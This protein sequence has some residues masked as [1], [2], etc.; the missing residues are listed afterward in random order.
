MCFVWVSVTK[1][2]SNWLVWSVMC[3]CVLLCFWKQGLIFMN[4]TW[5]SSQSSLTLF[6]LTAGHLAV[7]Q[8]HTVWFSV[9]HLWLCS[10]PPCLNDVLETFFSHSQMHVASTNTL[11]I[12]RQSFISVYTDTFF[13]HSQMHVASTNTLFIA[14]QSFISVYTDTFYI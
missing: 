10:Y 14:H 6:C 2:W 3:H 9:L 11:F 13:S 12:A 8:G 1:Y 5:C 7:S 4:L